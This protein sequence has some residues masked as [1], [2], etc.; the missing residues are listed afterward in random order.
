LF[1]HATADKRRSCRHQDNLE[2]GDNALDLCPRSTEIHE[3]AGVQPSRSQAVHALGR[4]HLIEHLYRLQFDDHTSIDKKV[5]QE[6]TD[7]TVSIENP[8]DVLLFHFQSAT[9]QLNGKRIFLN[10]F[11]KPGTQHIADTID[12]A[13]D[14]SGQ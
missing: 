11:E 2:A 8:Q 4:M 12:A 3:Q 6:L 13:D 10:L 7:Q 1:S 5:G 14:L 9:P